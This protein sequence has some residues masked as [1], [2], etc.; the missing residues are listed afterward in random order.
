MFATFS[1]DYFSN[2]DIDYEKLKKIA[3]SNNKKTNN[4]KNEVD[5]KFKFKDLLFGFSFPQVSTV[6]ASFLIAYMV[7]VYAPISI[8]QQS[9]SWTLVK[10]NYKAINEN[11]SESNVREWQVQDEGVLLSL[12]AIPGLDVSKSIYLDNNGA[13]TES[14]IIKT[15]C[16]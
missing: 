2:E 10:Q 16:Y 15:H 5:N 14:Y 13:I 9:S 3:F 7:G 4:L 6:L 12:K 1:K 11:V 8:F